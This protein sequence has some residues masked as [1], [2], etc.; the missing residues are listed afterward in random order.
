MDTD[1]DL[2]P[3]RDALLDDELPKLRKKAADVLAK[4]EE[5]AN[6]AREIGIWWPEVAGAFAEISDD[7]QRAA[8]AITAEPEPKY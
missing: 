3:I 7:L 2:T 8:L 5:R 1:L 6:L 4:I